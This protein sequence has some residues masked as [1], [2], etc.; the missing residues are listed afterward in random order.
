MD[1]RVIVRLDQL[2][3]RHD[4]RSGR[5]Q[6]RR[7]A[8][9]AGHRLDPHPVRRRHL[10]D[11]HRGARCARHRLPAQGGP[12][13]G[14]I[15]LPRPH[16]RVRLE[17][18]RSRPR[19]R[20]PERRLQDQGRRPRRRREEPGWGQGLLRAWRLDVGRG[21]RTGRHQ[22]G[23]GCARL[24]EGGHERRRHALDPDGHG[25][26]VDRARRPHRGRGQQPA[27]RRPLPPG[28]CRRG[29]RDVA[30]RLAA[31]RPVGP[32]SGPVASSSRTSSRAARAASCT[33]S[34]SPRHSSAC[35]STRSRHGSGAI[36]APRCCR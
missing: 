35:R 4:P 9:R 14:R 25:H 33:G 7:L 36:I 27:P 32:L 8:G 21:S 5:Q 30:P 28:P 19:R 23:V 6:L 16:H 15:G 3:D 17:P 31:A 34:A 11:D 13:I 20:A 2:G 10:R 12:G 29:P 1:D 24:P 22:G 18:D 26:R